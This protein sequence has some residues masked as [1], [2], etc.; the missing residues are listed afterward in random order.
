MP[1][2]NIVRGQKIE[3]GKIVRA[4]ELRRAMTPE[5]KL[6]WQHLRLNRLHGLHFRRQ[7]VIETL[8]DAPPVLGGPPIQP[9]HVE[10]AEHG[11]GLSS[12][13]F[14]SAPDVSQGQ[15]CV[16]HLRHQSRRR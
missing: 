8:R 4:R 11:I 12:H 14:E 15:R 5:E 1:V 2:P 3:T 9:T 6:L 7:Q 13:R 16:I 10:V